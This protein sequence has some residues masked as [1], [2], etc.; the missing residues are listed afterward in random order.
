MFLRRAARVT[1]Y[2]ITLLLA[3]VWIAS[4]LV[5]LAQPLFDLS[6]P[7]I[8]DAIIMLGRAFALAPEGIMRLAHMLAGLELLIGIYL[9]AT[10]A[11]AAVDWVRGRAVDDAMLDVGLL[12]S[13]VA[14][15]FSGLPVAGL[16]GEFLK[17]MIG[18][19]MLA[20]IASALAIYGRGF[21]VPVERRPLERLRYENGV[22]PSAF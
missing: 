18:E 13:A 7:H 19:L 3:L 10:V 8:G 12:I 9:M 20:V 2:L 6:R 22:L 4:A 16:G 21:V 5:A 1:S 14:T 15:V 17:G 11:A